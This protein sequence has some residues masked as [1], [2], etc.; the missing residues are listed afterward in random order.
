MGARLEEL[1]EELVIE[2]GSRSEAELGRIKAE[3]E[4]LNIAQEGTLAALRMKHNNSMGDLGEQIDSLNSS[5]VKSE[6]TRPVWSLISVMP[7]WT[8]KMLLRVRQ[9]WTKQESFSKDPLW[10]P[11]PDWMKWQEP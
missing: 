5:K 7:V 4:E 9:N 8:L 1:D 10:I 11:I 3:L 2:R 6:R